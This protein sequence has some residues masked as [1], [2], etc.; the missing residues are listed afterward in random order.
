MSE[1][2]EVTYARRLGV[3]DATMVVVGGVIGSGIFLTPAA[4][5]RQTGSSFEQ[6][7]AWGI[8][9]VLALIGA[10]CDAELGARR[11]NAGGGYVNLREAFGLVIAFVYGWNMLVVNYSGSLAAVATI[12]VQYAAAAL[13]IALEPRA[14]RPYA[15]ATIVFLAGINWFGIR[16]GSLAQNILTVLKLAAIAA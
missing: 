9:G 14:A 2:N 3:W 6:L 4:I 10:L 8:G 1:P 7:I 12:F 16:A 11:P 13:G 15:I 5:A